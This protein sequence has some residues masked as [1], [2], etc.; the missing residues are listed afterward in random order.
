MGAYHKAL[1]RALEGRWIELLEQRN[2]VPQKAGTVV[3]EFKLHKDGRVTDMK[4]VDSTVNEV[5]CL[6]CQKSVLD[7]CPFAHWSKEMQKSIGAEQCTLTLTFKYP[8]GKS[9]AN[10]SEGN[11]PRVLSAAEASQLAARLAND[12]CERQY[13]KRPFT[14]EQHS[15]LLEDGIYR[16]GGLDVGGPGGLSALVTFRRDGSQPHVEVYFSTDIRGRPPK[17]NPSTSNR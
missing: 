11:A 12:Q 16:W 5:L 15:A 2:Y 10:A 4:V 8:P 6:I 14:A 17:P 9:Q 3:L 7:L 13:R 1:L